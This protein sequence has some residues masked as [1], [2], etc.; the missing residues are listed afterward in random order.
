M[1]MTTQLITSFGLTEISYRTAGKTH[2]LQSATQAG[3]DVLDQLTDADYDAV[4]A[5]LKGVKTETTMDVA[6]APS[7][8]SAALIDGSKVKMIASGNKAMILAEALAYVN[9]I[10]EVIRKNYETVFPNIAAGIDAGARAEVGRRYVKII[11][12]ETREGKTH[13]R[14]A[15]GFVDLTNGDILKAASWNAP[16]KHARGNVMNGVEK[17]RRT[18]TPYGINY[19]R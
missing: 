3:A 7:A 1:S 2:I 10:S 16:A 4:E 18:F 19:L 11:S 9:E 17:R 14:S 13:D 12:T 15:F 5:A 6:S 8:A